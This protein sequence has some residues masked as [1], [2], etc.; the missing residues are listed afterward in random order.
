[1]LV[2]FAEDFKNSVG[3]FF[4][5]RE[6][7]WSDLSSSISATAPPNPMK[8]L[9]LIGDIISSALYFSELFIVGIVDMKML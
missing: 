4:S 9:Y 1:M 6:I 5:R 8:E 7:R 2:V 3:V